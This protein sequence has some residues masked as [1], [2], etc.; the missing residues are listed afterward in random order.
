MLTLRAIANGG[1]YDHIGGGFARYSVDDRW[2][3]P[4]FEKMLY[5]NAQLIELMTFAWLESGDSLFHRR[6]DETVAW[7]HRE[8]ITAGGAFAASLDADSEGHEGR[9]YVWA[10]D[11]V[12]DVLGRE[13]GAFVTE[14]YDITPG[15]NWE[16]VS[17]PNRIGKPPL[18]LA[19]E[20]RL[21]GARN[22]LLDRRSSRIRPMTDDKVLA[23]WNGLMIAALALAGST[24]DRADWIAKAERAFGFITESMMRDGRLAHSY[25]DGKLVFPGLATDYAAMIKAALALYAATFNRAYLDLAESL[26]ATLRRHHWD[27]REAGYFL[28]ADDAEALIVRLKSAQDDATPSANSLMGANLIRLWRLTG[29]DEY[30]QD[31]DALI[32]GAA[33]AVATNLFAM[34]GLLNALDLRLAARDVVIVRPTGADARPLLTAARRHLTP[35]TIL[36]LHEESADLP[37]TH[38]AAGKRPVDGKVTAYVCRGEVCSL[39]VTTVEDVRK[40]LT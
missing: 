20:H 25:R 31:A 15:G 17:I 39:P 40:L 33:P 6:I 14:A 2:L 34:T 37:P 32:A 27:S 19:E 24:F 4:H 5:D 9:F 21:A 23:D 11:E 1:I 10:F 22:R 36:S 13:E 28:S 8:M 26:A 16:G 29:K 7:L 3:V 12:I 38:P 30:R 35:N 18:S